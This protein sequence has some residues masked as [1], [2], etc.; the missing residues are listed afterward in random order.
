MET[1]HPWPVYELHR[2]FLQDNTEF[3]VYYALLSPNP[4]K[5]TI[6][7]YQSAFVF[8]TPL[9]V[10]AL[11]SRAV[12]PGLPRAAFWVCMFPPHDKL[13][14]TQPHYLGFSMLL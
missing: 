12:L 9:D 10:G 8:C 7:K 4:K 1:H 2:C 13:G 5:D 3:S 6:H 11:L 14:Q